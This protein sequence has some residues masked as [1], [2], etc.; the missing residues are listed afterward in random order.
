VTGTFNIEK[1]Q[2]GVKMSN[3]ILMEKSQP[4]DT[5]FKQPITFKTMK[6]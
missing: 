1:I 3:V 5:Y 6:K 2:T 4:F